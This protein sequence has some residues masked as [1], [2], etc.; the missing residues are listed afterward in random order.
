MEA[1]DQ[2]ALQEEIANS[3]HR[4][5]FEESRQKAMAMK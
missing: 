5:N 2:L 3:S 1:S 4:H